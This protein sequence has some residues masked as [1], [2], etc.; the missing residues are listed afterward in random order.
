M[1]ASFLLPFTSG[2]AAAA[3]IGVMMEM[4]S[5]AKLS[6]ADAQSAV[7][8]VENIARLSMHCLF[9]FGFAALARVGRA[10]LTFCCNAVSAPSQAYV[11]APV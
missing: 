9:G 6:T 5:F 11:D 8:L 1:T 4:C 2:T 10:N 3:T 7:M